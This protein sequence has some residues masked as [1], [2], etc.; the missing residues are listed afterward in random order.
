MIGV[1]AI[2]QDVDIGVDVAKHAADGMAFALAEFGGEDGSGFGGTGTGRV[3][4]VVV[5]D[6]DDGSGEREFEVTHDVGDG[7]FLIEAG[8]EDRE[9][10]RHVSSLVAGVRFLLK[11]HR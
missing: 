8:D 6:V 1:V 10:R 3:S 5:A 7:A 2:N 4:G 11:S 9:A